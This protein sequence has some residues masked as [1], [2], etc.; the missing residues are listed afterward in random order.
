MFMLSKLKRYPPFRQI[1]R[2]I[3]LNFAAFDRLLNRI[4]ALQNSQEL[5][6]ARQVQLSR[7]IS[8]A[9][10]RM[11]EE[12]AKAHTAA[13][14]AAFPPAVVPV[15]S[16]AAL[17]AEPVDIVATHNEVNGRHGTGVLIQKIFAGAESV[18]AIRAANT[19]DGEQ[20]FGKLQFCL[21]GPGLPRREIFYQVGN[22]LDSV[23]P[24]RVVAIPFAADDLLLAIAVKEIFRVPFCVYIMDDQNI[25]RQGIPDTLMREA[26]E[27]ADLRLAISPEMQYAYQNKYGYRF[28]LLPPV[29][30][31]NLIL[32]DDLSTSRPRETS[33]ART[34]I[35]A[36]NIWSQRW[37]DLLR[38]TVRGSGTQID[39]YCNNMRSPWLTFDPEDLKRDGIRCHGPIPEA[40]LAAR[41]RDCDFAL[42]PSGTMD[43]ADTQTAIAQLSL[44]S[45]VP[46]VVAASRT[47]IIAL[48]SPDSAVAGFLRRFEVGVV[49]PY[50]KSAY[51]NSVEEVTSVQRRRQFDEN[52]RRIGLTF[53][54]RGVKEWL[55]DSLDRGEPVDR[56][57]EDLFPIPDGQLVS[58]ADLPALPETP[59][60]LISV[61]Q[62]LRRLKHSGFEPDFVV[63]IGASTGVW[64][65]TVSK[66]FPQARFLLIDALSSRYPRGSQDK[67]MRGCNYTILEAAVSDHPGRMKL[68][69]SND[70]YNSSLL[71]VS[72]VAT[73]DEVKE[74]AVTTLDEIARRE[75]IQGRGLLKIDVQH[76]EHLILAGGN[77]FV[78]AQVDAVVLELTLDRPHPDA[79]TFG[80]MLDL[81]AKLGFQY[82]D[83]AGEWRNPRTGR[84]EQ[85]DV[86]FVRRPS[87]S[88]S[89]PLHSGNSTG[90]A[91]SPDPSHTPPPAAAKNRSP[92][93]H[94]AV[95]PEVGDRRKDISRWVWVLYLIPALLTVGYIARYAVNVPLTDEWGLPYLYSMLKTG[96]HGFAE[97]FWPPN[98]EHRVVVAKLI[99][100]ALAF[101]THWNLVLNMFLTFGAMLATFVWM[102]RV[103]IRQHALSAINLHAS[104]IA[105]GILLFSLA[106]WDTWLFSWQFHFVLAICWTI[107]AILVIDSPR[108]HAQLRLWVAI[109]L[110]FLATLSAYHGVLAWLVILPG[111][112]LVF[113]TRRRSVTAC[114]WLLACF[115]TTMAIYYID[116]HPS[117]AFKPDPLL[118]LKSPTQV[119]SFWLA[120]MGAPLSQI[121]SSTS[122][123]AEGLGFT[124]LALFA[125]AVFAS[126][127]FGLVRRQLAWILIGSYGVVADSMVAIG[128]AG[129]GLGVASTQ[130]RYMIIAVLIPVAALFLLAELASR[131]SIWRWS[132]RSAVIAVAGLSLASYP[133]FIEK[134]RL[135]HDARTMAAE[136]LAIMPY[137][138]PATDMAEQGLLFPLFPLVIPV[139]YVR[140]P[141]ELLNRVGLRRIEH[142]AIFEDNA[143][144]CGCVDTPVL[145]ARETFALGKSNA[146]AVSGWAVYPGKAT[147]PK[148]VFFSTDDRR[149]FVFGAKVGTSLRPDVGLMMKNQALV[150]SG[151]SAAIPA[152]FL[153]KGEF[154]LKAWAYDREHSRFLRLAD[155][156][157][158]KLISRS[159]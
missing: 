89:Q 136:S 109:A 143:P 139:S 99:W 10:Q 3:D 106:H 76:A 152:A 1:A 96:G 51:R 19:F 5:L 35:I 68:M 129:W 61:Y 65:G 64:S 9:L 44:P 144:L 118:I 97:T 103:A 88:P 145:K 157:G 14:A 131:S 110:C 146:L 30:S 33:A 4:E 112:Y 100:A 34:G 134:G 73:V 11:P 80:E 102:A 126:I 52:A 75:R 20:S 151:W 63:D 40:A 105:S 124:S 24:R 101:P 115:G 2:L 86:V 55:F 87:G 69:V 50:D 32:R 138:D 154:E 122:L 155:C 31:E 25:A 16:K 107:A 90:A 39:W 82:Y 28:W 141:A 104:V 150:R 47:P 108:L 23:E 26:V 153:P 72:R 159:L 81:M 45:R 27:K 156:N 98:N 57:Y 74:V 149:L 120:L 38:S 67:Y 84:L 135:L 17:L 21:P 116:Y 125:I 60:S 48:G 22:W 142:N 15:S 119:A 148:M 43:D 37:L 58:Y 123:V 13:A 114:F 7:L 147:V 128:R 62:V 79:R 94:L 111:V 117:G 121:F 113:P 78:A 59:K 95:N 158:P 36:G 130:S 137:I 29:V 92:S 133:R 71:H 83:D 41:L 70:L 8:E 49:C 127:R 77:V 18:I 53:S 140:T 46:F 91:L 85:K 56:R 54:D 66:L 6:G 132:F 12:T 93:A 42:L